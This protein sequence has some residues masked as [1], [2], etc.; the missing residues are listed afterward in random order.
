MPSQTSRKKPMTDP[1]RPTY[2]RM[3]DIVSKPLLLLALARPGG[4]GARLQ[5]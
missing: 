2:R 1:T 3:T 5:R 4:I